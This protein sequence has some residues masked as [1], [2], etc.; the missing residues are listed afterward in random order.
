MW[1]PIVLYV[2]QLLVHAPFVVYAFS[3]M[4]KAAG[5]GRWEEGGWVWWGMMVPAVLV[6]GGCGALFTVSEVAL[7]RKN[8]S[9]AWPVLREILELAY[10]LLMLTP[11]L[12]EPGGQAGWWMAAYAGRNA[13]WAV[14]AVVS[15]RVARGVR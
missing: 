5:G 8:P 9:L 6:L 10:A 14:L 3:R 1:A 12:D 4:V 7:S 11:I 15:Q 13:L 2:G